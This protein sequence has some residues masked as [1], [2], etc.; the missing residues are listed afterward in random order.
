[1]Q[2]AVDREFQRRADEAAKKG[3]KVEENFTCT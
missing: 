1:M 2:K 3:F